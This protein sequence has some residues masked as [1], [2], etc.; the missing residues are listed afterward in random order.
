MYKKEHST[1]YKNLFKH[2]WDEF[3][4]IVWAGGWGEG[5]GG[6]RAVAIAYKLICIFFLSR[7]ENSRY[8]EVILNLVLFIK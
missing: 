2:W 6:Y 5:L 3:V 4:V 7:K 8:F 1:K